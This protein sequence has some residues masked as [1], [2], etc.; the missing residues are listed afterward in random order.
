M[1][2]AAGICPDHLVQELFVVI[3]MQ[4][5]VGEFKR[6]WVHRLRK[7]S[8]IGNG[9]KKLPSLNALDKACGA[10]NFDFLPDPCV[11]GGN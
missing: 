9:G 3:D 5:D 2:D 11:G 8:D 10:Q 6:V 1:K 4:K 7:N